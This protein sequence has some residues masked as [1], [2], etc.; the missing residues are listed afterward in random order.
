MT[1]GFHR[2]KGQVKTQDAS[3]SIKDAGKLESKDAKRKKLL[4]GDINNGSERV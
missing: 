3:K 2:P 4:R 1:N